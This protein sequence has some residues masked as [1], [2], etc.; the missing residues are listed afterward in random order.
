[1]AEPIGIGLIGCGN[2]AELRHLPALGALSDARVVALAD[3]DSRNLETLGSRYQVRQLYAEAGA[4]LEDPAVEVVG[5]LVPAALH[6]EVVLAAV[7]AGKHVLVEK[8]LALST[9]DCARMSERADRSAGKVAVAFNLRAHRL[10]RRARELLADGLV[11][12]VESI[13]GTLVG[14]DFG[15]VD[16]W[17]G[18]R[19]ER[20]LGG[21]ALFE[22]GAHHY[23]L[24]RLL[25]GSEA[26][27]VSAIS[28][29]AGASDLATMV[30]ARMASGAL[31]TTTLGDYG[32]SIN[33]MIALGPRGRLELSLLEFD[34]LRFTP[35]SAQPG[36]ART[37]LRG[38]GNFLRELPRGL[39]MIRQGGEYGVTYR[40]EWEL[41]LDAI[42][43][44]RFVECTLEDGRKALEIALAAVASTVAGRTTATADAPPDL[45]SALAA[46]TTALE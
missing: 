28:R 25:T 31:A 11:G 21:G 23:D 4:L 8:P 14:G 40:R 44:D 17:Q 24:W 37:R 41:F 13:A 39:R 38:L 27:E 32:P 33:R 19:L 9:A 36:D 12:P 22:K 2:V 3:P 34:G 6:A 1:M 46:D 42:R 30:S 15:G 20:R 35:T 10:V 26:I 16:R 45:S 5:V 7:E 29:E 18:W 43:N